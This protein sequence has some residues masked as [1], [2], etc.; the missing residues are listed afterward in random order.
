MSEQLSN[1]ERPQMTEAQETALR[2]LCERYGV[3]YAAAHYHP[4]FDLPPDYVAGFIGGWE[5]QKEHPTLYV[6]CDGEGKI[7]S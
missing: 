4:T 7:S 1:P 5:I 2:G 3:E 6:G